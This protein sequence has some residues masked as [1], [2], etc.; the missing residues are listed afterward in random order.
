MRLQRKSWIILNAIATMVILI[1]F[2]IINAG[3]NRWYTRL[4]TLCPEGSKYCYGIDSLERE[5][6]L[7]IIQGWF[8]EL[9]KIQKTQSNPDRDN[10][11]L[12]LGL[13][14]LEKATVD[15]KVENTS[16]METKA[17]QE[18]RNDVNSYFSCEFDY[19][20]CGFTAS[21]DCDDID[22][23]VTPYRLAIKPDAK[24]SSKAIL[25]NVYITQEGISYTDPRNSL[26]LETE[27]TDLDTIV[28]GGVRL[29]SRPD[30]SC[31]VY[32][33]GDKLYWIVDNDF[34]FVNDGLTYMQYQMETTQVNTLPTDRLNND[35]VW[36][37][38]AGYF[39]EYEITN[40][41]KCGK[42]RVMMRDIPRDYPVTSVMTGY[43]DGER[44]LWQEVFK[45]NYQMLQ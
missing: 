30:H 14:P 41:I 22:L 42:Y 9:G 29:V 19:S 44:W 45:L 20:K 10:V 3:I 28:K 21:I 15:T 7:I 2:I 16:V 12:L 34:A 13:I 39:E 26:D 37:D 1:V 4:F 32:Q 5:G 11:E 17:A 38:M 6:N 33:L 24:E 36:S 23:S 8:F 25:T 31:Y 35:W 43:F 27:G 18:E 40:K